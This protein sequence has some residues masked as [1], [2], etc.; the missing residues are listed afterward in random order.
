MLSPH[1]HFFVD[2]SDHFTGWLGQTASLAYRKRSLSMTLDSFPVMMSR[3]TLPSAVGEI[4]RLTYSD[5][6]CFV[7]ARFRGICLSVGF[8]FSVR[9]VFPWP[10]AHLG[11]QVCSDL[12]H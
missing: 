11:F 8:I 7:L 4:G 9:H 10:L 6:I 3:F 5:T 1:F 2:L 12:E